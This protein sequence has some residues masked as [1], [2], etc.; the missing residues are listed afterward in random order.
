MALVATGP[1]VLT[2][3][4]VR[5]PPLAANQVLVR[6][7]A[8]ALN[9]SDHKL[10][11]QSTTIGATSGSDFAG[12]VVKLG[13]ANAEDEADQTPSDAYEHHLKV[14]D[15]VF[16]VVFGANPAEP[17]NGA[18][19]NFVAATADLCW[20]K[21]ESMK[22]EEAA[23]LGMAI[24]TTGL[25]FRALG[26]TLNSDTLTDAETS[27]SK[28]YVLVHGGATS[29]GTVA[30]Q[31][32]LQS[33][34]NPV[35]TCSPANEK[36]VLERGAVKAFSYADPAC[37]DEIRGYTE[38]QLAYCLDCIGN[39]N[40]MTICYGAIG[41]S[42]GSYVALEQYPR[43]L[44]I[45]RRNVTHGWVLGWTLFGKPVKLAGAYARPALPEDYAM[46]RDWTRATQPLI[47]SGLIKPHPLEVY[48]GGLSAVIPGLKMLR[49]GKIRG[50]KLVFLL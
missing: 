1:G 15:D 41:D 36:L 3:K 42:G 16:G 21:P 30:I 50:K 43:R 11:D 4:R 10:L 23:S 26:L 34:Y 40:T 13:T 2:Q 31:L 38:D 33:G 14:G 25:V 29:T 8:V 5:V 35:V 12:T 45:R 48:R 7:R 9:P 19:G 44:T 39:A 6:V 28:P 49:A 17:E 24:A 37:K 18:F 27:D 32:L 20:K 47:D 22:W 46:G